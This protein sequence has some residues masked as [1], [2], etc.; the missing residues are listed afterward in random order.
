MPDMLVKLYALPPLP[1]TPGYDIRPALTPEK[2]VV[3]NWIRQHFPGRWPDEADAAFAR[4]PVSCLVAHEGKNLLGFACYD[5]TLRGFFGPTGVAE[6]ARGRGIGSA[7]LL[8]TLHAMRQVGYGYAII[9]S[10]GPAAFYV[11]HCGATAIP[12]SSPGIYRGM[13]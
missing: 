3:L 10:A 5:A 2:G 4:V 12:D 11:K 9:G 8:H 13:L 7:L 1:P 6:A